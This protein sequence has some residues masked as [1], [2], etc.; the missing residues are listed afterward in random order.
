MATR[1]YMVLDK[2]TAAGYNAR[3]TSDSDLLR[4]ALV[5]AWTDGNGSIE[6]LDN[7]V[8]W[9]YNPASLQTIADTR[10]ADLFNMRQ[11]LEKTLIREDANSMPAGEPPAADDAPKKRGRPRKVVDSDSVSE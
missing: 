1:I 6:K 8:A 10:N 9:G 11:T 7:V 2:S 3:P 4:H 5:A